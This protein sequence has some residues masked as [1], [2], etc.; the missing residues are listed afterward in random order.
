MNRHPDLPDLPDLDT[1]LSADEEA[2]LDAEL[3]ATDDLTVELAQLFEVPADLRR[4]TAVEVTDGLLARSSL[5]AAVDLVALGWRTVRF[6][7]GPPAI[8]DTSEEDSR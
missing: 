4:R 2:A 6:L 8:A 7:A 1:G 5:S 3:A